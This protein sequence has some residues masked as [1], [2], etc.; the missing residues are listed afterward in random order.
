MRDH[1]IR[2]IACVWI[3]VIAVSYGLD[4]HQEE[5]SVLTMA[6]VE[7]RSHF[8]KDLVYRRWAAQHGGVYVP[9]SERTPPNPYLDHLPERDVTTTAGAQ[10]TLVNPAYMTRQVHELAATQY[11][12]RGHITSLDPLRPENRPDAWE[13][14]AL[15]SFEAG[16]REAMEGAQIDGQPFLRF[17]RPMIT[18]AGCLKCHAAQGYKFGQIRGGISVSVPLSPYLEANAQN[19]RMH[20]IWH[21]VVAVLGLCGLW[22]AARMHT[23]L[24]DD[25]RRSERKFRSLYS[26]MTEG[27]A[28]HRLITDASGQPV[29]Y[30]F[31]DVNPAFES[32]LGIPREKVLGRTSRDALQVGQAPYL[33]TYAKVA[34]TGQPA[35]F[36]ST[37]AS[38]HKTFAISAVSP[39]PGLFATVF[40][41]ISAHKKMEAQLKLWAESFTHAELGLSITDARQNVFIAVSP[42]FARQHGYAPEEMVGLSVWRIYPDDLLAQAKAS[43]TGLESASH[44]VIETEHVTRDGRRFPVMID[45]TVIHAPE[46][47]SITRVAYVLD[48][49]DRKRAEA[50][51]AEYHEHL[52]ELVEQRSAELTQA[53]LAAEAASIAKSAFLAQMSHEIRTPISGIL[54]MAHILR[55]SRLDGAQL[56]SLAKIEASGRHLLGIIDDIL[57]LS[58]IEAGK[59]QLE[60]RDFH[61]DDMLRDIRA[62]AGESIAAR[63]LA[64]RCDIAADVPHHLHGDPT[65]L[66]QAIV[67]YLGNATKFTERGSITLAVEMLAENAGK[68]L[69]RFSVA[70]TGIG[71]E[72]E[73]LA[74]IFDSFEQADRST[75]RK[76]GGTGLGLSITRNLARLMGGEVGVDSTPGQGS[77]FWLTAWLGQ[78]AATAKDAPEEQEDVVAILRRD[79]AGTR[80]LLAEDEPTNR[81]IAV[82]LLEDAGLRVDVADNGQIA[83][84]LAAQNDY[85]LILMDMQMPVMNGL[86]A[87]QA[88]RALPAHRHTPI[89]A[90]TANAF[91]EDRAQCLAAGMDDF[92]SKPFDPDGMLRMLLRWLEAQPAISV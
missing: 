40:E 28:L 44:G 13:T 12:V 75:T 27:V 2:I 25:L 5:H 89:L 22:L 34:A 74:R 42:S 17:M 80:V 10:M 70:D 83:A 92:I 62:I 48:I 73:A 6:G 1:V 64:F 14:Q 82:F 56:D 38:L 86:Q 87:T 4:L 54:G 3:V 72:A 26:A 76:F 51:L 50:Q 21:I 31:I 77:R 43:I 66:T 78:A 67:N 52:E 46:D 63:N 23:R 84:E 37:F 60:P 11:G 58:K 55:R 68:V 30:E 88:I 85:R 8:E 65:R 49:T 59:L 16:A 57:D 90:M 39:G 69:L 29:D 35:K 15:Q 71:I 7:A 9:R 20:Q 61:L 18:E 81:D 32:M 53:K 36:E 19:H 33:E 47:D 45:V 41:D 79:H 24:L 91:A